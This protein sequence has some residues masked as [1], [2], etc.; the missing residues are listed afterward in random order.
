[1]ELVCLLGDRVVKREGC[2]HGFPDD[3]KQPHNMAQGENNLCVGSH[4][5]H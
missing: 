4:P 1:M 3:S 5:I 2:D